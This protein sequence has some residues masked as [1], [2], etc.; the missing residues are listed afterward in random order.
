MKAC[1]VVCKAE[2]SR[3]WT[4][5]ATY[6]YVR[7]SSKKHKVFGTLARPLVCTVCGYV[8][9]FVNPEDFRD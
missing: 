6:G 4:E 7:L 1:V 8:E 5:A 3:I 2:S 9:H